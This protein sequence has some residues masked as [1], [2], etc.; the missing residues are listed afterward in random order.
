MP[1]DRSEAMDLVLRTSSIS[2]LILTTIIMLR[3]YKTTKIYEKI[4]LFFLFSTSQIIAIAYTLSFFHKINS[5]L[6]WVLMNLFLL[7]ISSIV[8]FR[9]RELQNAEKENLRLFNIKKFFCGLSLNEKILLVPALLT[10]IYNLCASFFHIIH[11]P[12]DH[13]DSLTYHLPRVAYYLQHG[14]LNFFEANYW[15][16]A[17]HAKNSS[18][19][20][21]YKFLV[22]GRNENFFQLIQFIAYVI[23]LV[24]VFGISRAIHLE[25][26]WALF[27]SLGFGLFIEPLLEAATSQNDLI[28]GAYVGITV[29]FLLRFAAYK[30]N[31]DIFIVSLG[32]AIGLGVKASFLTVLPSFFII[33]LCLLY[34][35]KSIPFKKL[36]AMASIFIL[37]AMVFVLPAGYWENYRLFDNPLGPKDIMD[38]SFDGH[39]TAQILGYGG[40]NLVR[41][42][43]DFLTLDGMPMIQPIF[44]VQYF[45]KILPVK[46]IELMGLGTIIVTEGTGIDITF[47]HFKM[48]VISEDYSYLGI[49]GFTILWPASI[50]VLAGQLKNRLGRVLALAWIIFFFAQAFAGPYDPF[51]GRYFIYAAVFAS[52]LIGCFAKE[53]FSK[54]YMKIYIMMVLFI[55]CFAALNAVQTSTDRNLKIGERADRL[56]LIR[57][58]SEVF[59]KYEAV[60][61]ADAAVAVFL[62]GDSFEYQLFGKGLTRK[63]L[64]VNFFMGPKTEIPQEAQYL[65]F[66]KEFKEYIHNQYPHT[67]E[68][69]DIHLGE[70]YYLKELRAT[71]LFNTKGAGYFLCF[72]HEL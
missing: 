10:V 14:N 5:I 23:C 63:I 54:K 2:A 37:F 45:I 60:V 11:F 39:S 31:K 48:P 72:S 40:L 3:I 41:Y 66:Q 26:K 30:C 13:W 1:S 19:L 71:K 6:Y 51:R 24:A 7:M 36:V 9:E 61:P 22:S 29:Y 52:P 58:N 46:V 32:T 25:I 16:Q 27:S 47:N 59:K 70:E 49:L 64:P 55:S 57:Y 53:L 62:R 17:V 44:D 65:I 15:A 8:Y 20:L 18:A 38:H 4:M 28:I 33:G 21:L 69:E 35:N 68:L 56:D 42:G 43:M 50:L 34:I 12:P 67:K